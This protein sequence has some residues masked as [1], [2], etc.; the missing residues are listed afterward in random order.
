MKDVVIAIG[1]HRNEKSACYFGPLL[2]SNLGKLGYNVEL[3]ENPETRTLMEIV[4]QASKN[5]V[6]MDKKVIKRLLYHW[7][8]Y[9]VSKQYSDS[10]VFLLHNGYVNLTPFEVEV[11]GMPKGKEAI[12]NVPLFSDIEILKGNLFAEMIYFDKKYIYGGNNIIV[13]IPD[14]IRDS[15]THDEIEGVKK[16]F[17]R[18]PCELD[19]YLLD[20]DMDKTRERGWLSE[21][22]L[23]FLTK[24]IDY[25][26]KNGYRQFFEHLK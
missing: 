23:T 4:L 10:Y 18:V 21:E 14:V 2:A 7:E 3:V 19:A 24:G 12:T 15:Y 26:L 17:G 22:F 13:E 5:N 11:G 25:L 6:K 1:Q 8:D 9:V 20:T 16:V